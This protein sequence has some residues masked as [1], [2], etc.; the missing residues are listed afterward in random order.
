MKLK[1][2]LTESSNSAKIHDAL[3]Q[4][5]ALIDTMNSLVKPG[6]DSHPN[7]VLKIVSERVQAARKSFDRDFIKKYYIPLKRK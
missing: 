7:E 1:N 2:I 5:D 3:I 4:F 6:D